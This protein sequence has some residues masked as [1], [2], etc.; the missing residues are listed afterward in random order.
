MKIR[1]ASDLHYEFKPSG[2]DIEKD[3]PRLDDDEDT[4]L[5]LAGDIDVGSPKESFFEALSERFLAVIYITGNHEAYKHNIDTLSYSIESAAYQDNVHLLDND[6]VLIEDTTFYGGTCWTH[7]PE[8]KQYEVSI[9]MNDFR[10][11]KTVDVETSAIQAFT[12]ADANNINYSF[13]RGLDY[14]LAG[15]EEDTKV[16]VVTHHTPSYR[17]CA[18]EYTGQRLNVAYHNEFDSLIED[19][20][21]IKLWCHGHV[22]SSFDYKIGTSRIL[23]NPYGY[24]EYEE[25]QEF[26]NEL[27]VEV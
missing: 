8:D 5:V 9:G 13:K 11:I 16:V 4:V 14:L 23:C 26:D 18:P 15:V 25:N 17:S 19:N 1:L 22:H 27:T 20:P 10:A 3:I 24:Y 6:S 7:V 12:P 2:Y 21:V